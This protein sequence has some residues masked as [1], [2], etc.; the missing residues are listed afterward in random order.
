[1]QEKSERGQ[2][3][4]LLLNSGSDA[5]ETGRT[6]LSMRTKRPPGYAE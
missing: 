4:A 6:D 5:L 2:Q 3:R 1:M